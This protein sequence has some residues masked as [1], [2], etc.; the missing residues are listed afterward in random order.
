MVRLILI[1]G[2]IVLLLVLSA[3]AAEGTEL[4]G[5][6]K[7]F[8]RFTNIRPDDSR[9]LVRLCIVP[10]HNQPFSW[11]GKT[12]YVGNDGE[13]E[14]PE[15]EQYFSPGQAS[16]WVDVGQYM[17]LQGTR[18]WDTYLSPLLCGAMTDPQADGL[19]LL[20]EIAQG[21]GIRVVR[22][23]AIEKSDL[24]AMATQRE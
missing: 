24:P 21:P 3:R 8:I 20:A 14:N 6:D 4:V 12:V 19:Y 1:L 9:I 17:N 5:K 13:G 23:L 10:N 11:D 7:I 18:S 16:P 22:R 2:S 15:K